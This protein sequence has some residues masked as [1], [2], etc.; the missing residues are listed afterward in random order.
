MSFPVEM[1]YEMAAH[2]YQI[3]NL[4]LVNKEVY[5]ICSTDAFWLNMNQYTEE[6]KLEQDFL[7][8]IKKIYAFFNTINDTYTIIT[9]KICYYDTHLLQKHFNIPYFYIKNYAPL[10]IIVKD[11]Q[12]KIRLVNYTCTIDQKTL[13]SLLFDCYQQKKII[14]KLTYIKL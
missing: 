10:H 5:G 2:N 11:K 7:P 12:Y 3:N 8:I 9:I 4:R 13:I 1:F 14:T 6:Q